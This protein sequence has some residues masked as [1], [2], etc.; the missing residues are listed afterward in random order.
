[1][2]SCPGSTANTPPPTPLLAGMPTVSIQPPEKSYIPQEAITLRTCSTL[3]SSMARTPVTGLIPW[4]ARVAPITARSTQRTA[5][6]H[7]LK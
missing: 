1:M 4:L 5:I 6:E 3:A 2:P 7:C